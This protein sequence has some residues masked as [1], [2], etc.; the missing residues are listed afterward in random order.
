[1]KRWTDP[2]GAAW[3]ITGLECPICSLPMI[4]VPGLVAHPICEEVTV[5]SRLVV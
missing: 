1:M 2:E 3:P 5:T 4:P